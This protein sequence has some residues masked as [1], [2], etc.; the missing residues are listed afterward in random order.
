MIIPIVCET[1][2]CKDRGR[3][4]NQVSGIL[5]PDVNLFFEGYDG[6][7]L[8]DQCLVCGQVGVAQDPILQ[9]QWENKYF[10]RPR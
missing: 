10:D 3:E 9:H 5:P 6:S 7:E 8:E 1:P 2:G 4:L